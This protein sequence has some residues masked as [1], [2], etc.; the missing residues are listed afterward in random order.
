MPPDRPFRTYALLLMD[1]MTELV[2][3]LREHDDLAAR[4]AFAGG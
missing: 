3:P 1:V 4:V 2:I